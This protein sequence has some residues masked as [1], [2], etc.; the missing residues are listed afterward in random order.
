LRRKI[1]SGELGFANGKGWYEY[2]E[3][4][5]ATLAGKRA[6]M[7]AELAACLQSREPGAPR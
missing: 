2:P 3:G 7:L 4:S 1:E 6:E 5:P